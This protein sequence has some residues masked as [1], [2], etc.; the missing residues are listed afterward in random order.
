MLFSSCTCRHFA[1]AFVLVTMTLFAAPLQ[2]QSVREQLIEAKEM[3]TDGA[4][5]RDQEAL[6][7]AR[8]LFEELVGADTLTMF[9]HYYA[10][11]A[12]N[13]L[14]NILS[15]LEEGSHRRQILEYVNYAIMHFEAA[16]ALDDNF[17]EGW[18]LLSA[19]YAQ[20]IT[21]TPLKAI[22]LGRKFSKAMARARELAPDNPRVVLLGAITDYNLPRI[23]GGNKERAVGELKEAATLFANEVVEDSVLPSW[24]HEETYARLGIAFMDEGNLAEAR[25]SFERSLEIN[26]D[27]GWVKHILIP[28]LEELEAEVAAEN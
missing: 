11:S 13:E 7:R 10:A 3:L 8:T 28:S 23:V 14:A 18:L 6:L 2:G 17:A 4:N 21:V 27:F 19:S 25:A 16:T 9:A 22:G 24:G 1:L 5:R 20:K 12:A 26:P 15:Q